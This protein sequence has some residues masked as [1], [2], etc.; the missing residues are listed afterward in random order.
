MS[1]SSNYVTW[2]E[3]EDPSKWEWNQIEE[4]TLVEGTVGKYVLA[5]CQFRDGLTESRVRVLTYS[6]SYNCWLDNQLQANSLLRRVK[7]LPVTS[8]ELCE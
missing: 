1:S 5:G 4:Q 3:R 7:S 8:C 2:S 6:G